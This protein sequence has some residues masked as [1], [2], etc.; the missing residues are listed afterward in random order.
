MAGQDDDTGEP[1]VP[2]FPPPGMR[3]LVDEYRR[4]YPAFRA[5]PAPGSEP[6]HESKHPLMDA[7]L[8]EYRAKGLL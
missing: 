7:L 2:T 3:A 4:K 5:G 6:R 8:E 1:V